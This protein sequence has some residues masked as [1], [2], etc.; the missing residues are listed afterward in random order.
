MR[1]IAHSL[2]LLLSTLF[3]FTLTGCAHPV[4]STGWCEDM[5]EKPKGEWSANEA[6]DYMR[7]CIFK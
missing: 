1:K 3:V 5:R 4:G 7:H 6:T 2:M